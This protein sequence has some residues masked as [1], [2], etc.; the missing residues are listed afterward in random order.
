[1]VAE[2]QQSQTPSTGSDAVALQH[3]L[4]GVA[5]LVVAALATLIT[6][7]KGVFP[8]LLDAT[9]FWS[10]GRV[11]AMATTLT[12][13]GWLTPTM[14]GAAY[15]L[16]PRLSGAPLRFARVSLLN[17]WFLTGV[18]IAS[19][20]SIG[21]GMGDGFELFEFPMW[22][23]VL[24]AAGLIVPLGVVVLSL[25][26]RLGAP[27]SIPLLYMTSAL[28]W[29]AALGIVA[30][31]FG[32][33]P[34][35]LSL[36]SAFTTSG[37][38]F[39][40]IG[41][42]SLAL[43]FYLVPHLTG[44]PLFS[45]QLAR[46]GFWALAIGGAA[47][48]YAR[49][50][51]GPAP[52]WLETAAVVLAMV[53]II[54]AIAA[55][56]NVTSTMRTGTGSSPALYFGLAA[57]AGLSVAIVM[58]ALTGFRSVAAVVGLTPWWDGTS[59]LL[60]FGVGGWATAALVYTA[61]PRLLGRTLFSNA[62]AD[63]HLRLTVLGVATTTATLWLI[64]LVSGFTWAGG[65]YSGTSTATGAGFATTLESVSGLWYVV[66]IGVVI[67]VVGLSLHVFL[68]A[69]TLTSGEPSSRELLVPVEA[70]GE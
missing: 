60:L 54:T 27:P 33:D 52:D 15:Y 24:L 69:R 8:S 5:F 7:I 47:A 10:Y 28:L 61:V 55:L 31:L 25:R 12:V 41:G 48:G 2:S 62:L 17:L 65:N 49:Y 45:P 58:S 29:L 46:T 18:V 22:A 19:T 32:F 4:L 6:T 23:D 44:R 21:L 38:H 37:I 16:V 13:F 26:G 9:G 35:G 57:V 34:V 51:H 1:M 43:V 63:W 56:T 30:N 64:G 50:T 66:L 11:R 67:T 20:V 53:L 40:W 59:F 3:L 14:I 36:L 39:L 42:A 68:V 70:A